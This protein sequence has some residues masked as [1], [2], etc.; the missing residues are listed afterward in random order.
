MIGKL[1]QEEYVNNL[2]TRV[3]EETYKVAQRDAKI[4]KQKLTISRL[5]KGVITLAIVGWVA[6]LIIILT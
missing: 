1:T 3:C 6:V 4:A 5:K 2:E